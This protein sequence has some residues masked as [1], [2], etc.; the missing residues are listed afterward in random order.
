ML[1][2]LELEV[3]AKCFVVSIGKT[4][5]MFTLEEDNEEIS[6]IPRHFFVDIELGKLIIGGLISESCFFSFAKTPNH[7]SKTILSNIPK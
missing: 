3:L 2:S 6:W 4:T 1:K 5:K 7:V